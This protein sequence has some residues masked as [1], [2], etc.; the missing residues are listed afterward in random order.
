LQRKAE[1][2][3]L[4]NIQTKVGNAEALDLGG[5]YSLACAFSSLY[6]LADLPAFFKRLARHLEPGG[7][8][9]FITT[10]RSLFRLFTQIGN[11]AR[12]GLWLKAHSR[13]EI[14]AMLAGALRTNLQAGIMK[15]N[16]SAGD[17][18]A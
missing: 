5:T 11:A 4:D 18:E 15:N 6:S 8:L 13:G 10:R 14:E 16:L 7:S 9:Y 2:E 17:R 12:Q 3:R 1:E